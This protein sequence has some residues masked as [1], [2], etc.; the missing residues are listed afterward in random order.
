MP[1]DRRRTRAPALDAR[2]D[3]P[4]RGVA[5][6]A[7][8]R[9]AHYR[10]ER[11]IIA[12]RFPCCNVFYPCHACHDAVADHPAKPW[13]AATDLDERAVLCGTCRTV[14]TWRQYLHAEDACPNCGADFNPGCK[15]HLHL[16]FQ[17]AESL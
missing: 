6:D 5:V 3:V 9:C 8:T 13:D 16:Y 14:L 2:F 17:N 10:T 12:I 7:H 15:T 11:D 4:L 1:P